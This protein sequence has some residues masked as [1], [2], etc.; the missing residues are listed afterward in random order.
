MLSCS[1]CKESKDQAVFEDDS[2][3]KRCFDATR[4]RKQEEKAEDRKKRQKLEMQEREKNH[5][6]EQRRLYH[7]THGVGYQLEQ[8]PELQ[9]KTEPLVNET[10]VG[11]YELVFYS[12]QNI[13]EDE[14][15]N[16]E[17]IS[18]TARGTLELSMKECNDKPALFGFYQIDTR[19]SNGSLDFDEHWG[20]FPCS[21]F[22]ENVSNCDPNR[23]GLNGVRVFETD[24][25]ENSQS[26]DSSKGR[27]EFIVDRVACQNYEWWK[28]LHTREEDELWNEY[29]GLVMK[30]FARRRALALYPKK[31]LHSNY[32]G[33]NINWSVEGYD[34]NTDNSEWVDKAMESYRDGRNSWMCQ[35]LNV[36]A[37]VAFAI[38]EFVT[39]P[40]VFYVEEGE[41]VTYV[42][43]SL[44]IEWNKTLIFR[45]VK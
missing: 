28:N 19:M 14:E 32:Y 3:C 10:L 31:N 9:F 15:D 33:K 45:K 27:K 36:P 1:T 43:E 24:D 2:E 20:K 8:S 23:L 7:L 21:V 22:I 4:K 35:H 38:R 13:G 6:E 34:Y 39:P 16:S 17:D 41:L 26:L 29:C 18:R 30:V 44:P 40:P 37:E 5:R 25:S 12:S 11:K 42:Q